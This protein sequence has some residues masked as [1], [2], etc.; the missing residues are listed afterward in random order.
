[1]LAL[2]GSVDRVLGKVDNKNFSFHQKEGNTMKLGY[3]RLTTAISLAILCSGVGA[4]ELQFAKGPGGKLTLGPDYPPLPGD[5][6]CRVINAN[7]SS[8][9]LQD[10]LVGTCI[11]GQTPPTEGVPIRL[12]R[13]M[14]DGSFT[15]ITET[16]IKG[17]VPKSIFPQHLTVADFNGDGKS[18]IFSAN[19]GWDRPPW[20]GEKSVLML[21]NADGTLSDQSQVIASTPIANTHSSDAADIDGDG[22]LDIYVGNVGGSSKTPPYFLMGDGKGGFKVDGVSDNTRIPR[23]M[24][25]RAGPNVYLISQFVDVNA[26]GKPDLVLGGDAGWDNA[27]NGKNWVLFNDGKGHFSYQ[28]GV[29]LP[30]TFFGEDTNTTSILAMDVNTDGKVD[31]IL[32]ETN[33][34][35]TG[36]AIQVLINDG[37]GNFTD[38]T[39]QRMPADTKQD[40]GP[41][42]KKLIA[43]DINGDGAL[44]F[45]VQGMPKP[46]ITGNNKLFWLNDGKGKFT[47]VDTGI[48]DGDTPDQ[49]SMIDT[50]KDGKLDIVNVKSHLDGNLLYQTY[51]QK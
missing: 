38:E 39:S 3:K 26:D 15:E 21:S 17:P 49:V 33:R 28:N 45:Y 41:W 27:K 11:N 22:A 1:M 6:I 43:A 2:D 5:K 42:F 24:F 46:A 35:Y 4:Q 18:D 44:D 50:N 32:A 19:F 34:G 8:P 31:L 14:G 37:K 40:R 23:E 16:F 47:S 25:K 48:I 9:D 30:D 20:S 10:I 51:L 36:T 7:F 13:N 12:L 29:K